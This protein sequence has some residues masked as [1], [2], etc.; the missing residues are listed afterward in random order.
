MLLAAQREVCD[1]IEIVKE[2]KKQCHLPNKKHV[3][4]HINGAQTVVQWEQENGQIG[5]GAKYTS[6]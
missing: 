2:G 3:F 1:L 5:L 4:A 6:K